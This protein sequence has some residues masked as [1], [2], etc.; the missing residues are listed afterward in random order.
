MSSASS[1]GSVVGDWEN[2]YASDFSTCA[3]SSAT[4]QSKIFST[5]PALDKVGTFKY[6]VSSGQQKVAFSDAWLADG[7]TCTVQ[8]K[9]YKVAETE[10]GVIS[11]NLNVINPTNT[12]SSVGLSSIDDSIAFK[13][14][15]ISLLAVA[16]N[17]Q[18]VKLNFKVTPTVC[19]KSVID[20]LYWKP[21]GIRSLELEFLILVADAVKKFEVPSYEHSLNCQLHY[22]LQE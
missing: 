1:S 4:T 20:P 9:E 12:D 3:K 14:H 6:L 2:D 22:L 13:E 11:S 5:T 17:N 21:G 18:C 7:D 10:S 16:S 8:L 15:E 19:H